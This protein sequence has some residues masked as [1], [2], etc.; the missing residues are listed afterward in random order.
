MQK[1]LQRLILHVE[2]NFL[3]QKNPKLQAD[4]PIPK[5][6]SIKKKIL[7]RQQNPQAAGN[8]RPIIQ[9]WPAQLKDSDYDR[10]RVVEIK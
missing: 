3:S 8:L 9:H 10:K 5:I 1:I 7:Q 6:V 4:P 2:F